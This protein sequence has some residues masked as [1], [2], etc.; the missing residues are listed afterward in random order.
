[1]SLGCFQNCNLLKM[2]NFRKHGVED[3]HD[4]LSLCRDIPTGLGG[5]VF[6]LT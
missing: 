2:D 4:S 6:A 1:V 5:K 3:E